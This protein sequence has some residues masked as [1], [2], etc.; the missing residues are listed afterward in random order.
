MFKPIRHALASARE[1]IRPMLIG[2]VPYLLA[3]L[4][5][6]GIGWF[7]WTQ[8][9]SKNPDRTAVADLGYRLEDDAFQRAL[10]L[11][12]DTEAVRKEMRVLAPLEGAVPADVR[13]HWWLGQDAL[14]RAGNPE[15]DAET[16]RKFLTEAGSR[17]GKVVNRDL[18]N[19]EAPGLLA[20]V[21]LRLGKPRRAMATLDEHASRLPELHVVAAEMANAFGDRSKRE[22]HAVAAA[23]HFKRIREDA[24]RDT[25]E[26]DEAL[27]LWARAELMLGNDQEARGILRKGRK[28][29]MTEERVGPLLAR[30]WLVTIQRDLHSHNNGIPGQSVLNSLREA[31]EETG[32]DVRFIEIAGGLVS[33]APRE[34]EAGL[35]QFYDRAARSSR[36]DTRNPLAEA[37]LGSFALA[38]KRIPQGLAHLESVIESDPEHVVALNNLAYGLAFLAAT[39][40]IERALSLVDRSI[41]AGQNAG[42]IP[43]NCWETR[44][45]ILAKQSRWPEAAVDLERALAGMPGHRD[46]HET[47]AQVYADCQKPELAAKHQSLA[48][49]SDE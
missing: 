48:E 11:G 17:I 33:K 23:T 41:A 22:K 3:S 34:L 45:Q 14:A 12:D 39:P 1:V 16:A 24:S 29:G 44:G 36:T 15:T 49:K 43:P 32:P 28:A 8:D 37:A 21:Q 9:S 2:A 4:A 31:V 5:I 6:G 20:Q 42:H 35:N 40:D 7:V 10:A 38:L 27:L 13:A 46:I 47:L 30:T 18:Q 26:R 19:T 25:G